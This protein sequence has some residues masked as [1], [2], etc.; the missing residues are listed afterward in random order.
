MFVV[1]LKSFAERVLGNRIYMEPSASLAEIQTFMH[2]VRPRAVRTPLVRIGGR[3]DGGYLLPDDFEGIKTCISPGVSNEVSFDMAMAERGI[4]V[5]MADASVDGPPIS[6][7]RFHFTRKFLDVV[8][9]EAHMR[10]DTLATSGPP[11][12]N[13]DR[14]LQMDIEG[15]EYRVLLDASDEVL[16]SFR[17]I[18]V[19]FHYLTRLFGKFSFP[20]VRAAFQKLL[21]HHF[22]VHVHPNN[23]SR[24]IVRGPLSV[25]EAMEFTFWRKDRADFAEGVSLHFPHPLDAD[26]HPEYPSVALPLCWR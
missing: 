24:P 8:D 4:H 12:R 23:V 13:G 26:C 19:E 17:I 9:D 16:Q 5:Y 3:A 15:A 1:G 14:I 21:R 22:V 18:V 7:E 20:L 11:E 6:N 2:T 10:L 25:P